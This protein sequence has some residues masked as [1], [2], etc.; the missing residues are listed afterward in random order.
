MNYFSTDQIP[1]P[2]RLSFLHD[3]VGRQVAGRR[4][5]PLDDDVSI[6]MGAYTLSD[7]MKVCQ[8]R[9]SPIAGARTREHL[10]DGND[11]YLLTV[12][13]ADCE[14]AI[15]GAA[16]VHVKAGDIMLVCEGMQAEFRLPHV[17]VTV[18]SLG[19]REMMSR[20]RNIESRP[21]FLIP[22]EAPGAE[23]MVGYS[24][25]LFRNAAA[26]K[27]TGGM[28][29]NHFFDLT[30]FALDSI[31][32]GA[33]DRDRSALGAARLAVIKR[34]IKARLHDPG[35]TIGTIA[36]TQSVTPRYVQQLF[37]R[38]GTTFSDHVR[39]GRLD[40]ARSRLGDPALPLQDSI[41]AIAYDCGF[42]DLSHFNR[43]FKK[44]F[45]LTPSDVR[46]LAMLTRNR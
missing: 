10:A 44:R 37:E 23:L 42:S 32:G 13:D 17:R 26:A 35:L 28:A 38:E 27:A 1:R 7:S 45:G 41:S 30:A 19:F 6:E 36:R 8:A 22:A 14:L 18:V 33:P 43:S 20:V 16:P 2:Q 46:G 34:E 40:R 12:H 25:L 24:E 29:A 21:Y 4:Y 15:A 11:N 31:Y 39:D 9:Y 5:R 3:F